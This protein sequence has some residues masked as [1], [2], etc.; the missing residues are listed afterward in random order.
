MTAELGQRLEA[1]GASWIAL[2]PRH[3]SARKRR[4]GTA[5][6][7]EVN[8]LKEN[9]QVPVVSNGN[10]RVWQDVQDNRAATGADGIM[11]GETLLGNPW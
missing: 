9:V 2:H 8:R 10:V 6:L 7:D 4:Q 3:T 11:V 1:A 5:F